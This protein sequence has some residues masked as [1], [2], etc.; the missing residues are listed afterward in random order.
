[1]R[2]SSGG[3]KSSFLLLSLATINED[4]F[5]E[6][7]GHTFRAARQQAVRNSGISP[8]SGTDFALNCVIAKRFNLVML[9]GMLPTY[10]VGMSPTPMQVEPRMPGC[11]D[12]GTLNRIFITAVLVAGSPGQAEAAMLE[13][14]QQM[15]ETQG[16]EE[17]LFFA[18][19]RVA[20]NRG[21]RLEPPVKPGRAASASLSLP[22]ELERVMLLP[23][24]FRHCFVLRILAGLSY[25]QCL[26]LNI[27]DPDE[28][29]CSAARELSKHYQ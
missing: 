17:D 12:K 18:C 5:S 13:A 27:K 8:N 26:F 16:S 6:P 20:L 4:A 3:A 21:P 14:I 2:A 28:G 11:I 24:N 22:E 10:C 9:F 19:I 7:V 15:D 25:E 29:A 23:P 1:M